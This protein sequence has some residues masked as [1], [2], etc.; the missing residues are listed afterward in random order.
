[1]SWLVP[2][3]GIKVRICHRPY[4]QV[5]SYPVMANLMTEIRSLFALIF[6]Q[7]R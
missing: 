2:L 3:L 1:M 6:N 7:L 4:V 5:K